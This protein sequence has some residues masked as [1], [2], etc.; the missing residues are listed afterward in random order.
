MWAANLLVLIV[1]A[2]TLGSLAVVMPQEMQPWSFPPPASEVS[3]CL[4]CLFT[5]ELEKQ[6]G[7]MRPSLL[8][9]GVVGGGVGVKSDVVN[10]T[11]GRT[12]FDDNCSVGEGLKRTALSSS[13]R[14][15]SETGK[16]AGNSKPVSRS[17]TRSTSA[18]IISL[19]YFTNIL[20]IER[21]S[22]N[23]TMMPPPSAFLTIFHSLLTW[24]F[25]VG[26][27]ET[28]SQEQ[29]WF[30]G[31]YHGSKSASVDLTLVVLHFPSVCMQIV[32]SVSKGT[33]QILHVGQRSQW[34]FSRVEQ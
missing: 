27:R 10:G 12:S 31:Q 25:L 4:L 24:L 21:L 11:I 18:I 28:W 29:C 2:V 5:A 7:V 13:L 17:S 9:G 30:S 15:L 20:T 6:K 32:K 1:W 8:S 33:V 14:D 34:F 16:T 23:D 19:C 26:C 3:W 22:W